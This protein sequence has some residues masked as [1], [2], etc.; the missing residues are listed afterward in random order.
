MNRTGSIGVREEVPTPV[1]ESPTARASQSAQ[2]RATRRRIAR[3]V[4]ILML[5]VFP[6]YGVGS[7]VATRIAASADP[8]ASGP[9][10][11]AAALAMLANSAMVIGIGALMSSVLRLYSRAIALTYLLTRIFEGVGL[12]VGVVAL[13]F[14]DGAAALQINSVAYNVSM[15][16]LGVGSLFFCSLLFKTRLVPR[17]L[18]VSGLVG[19]ATIATG[20]LLELAGAAG[21]GV[22]AAVPGGLFELAF[23]VWLI[24]RGFGAGR[25]AAVPSV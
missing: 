11:Y 7:S 2:G 20:C 19:Y 13:V 1:S 12:A 9:A 25:A 15:A 10:L 5:A 21:V 17:P 4:G 18:A 14:L 24:V 8:S 23:G 6:A 22:V 3:A 16:A